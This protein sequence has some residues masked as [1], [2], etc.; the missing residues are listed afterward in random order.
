RAGGYHGTAAC[1][2]LFGDPGGGASVVA[3]SCFC[4]RTHHRSGL[5]RLPRAPRRANGPGRSAA[6]RVSPASIGTPPLL[7]VSLPGRYRSAVGG[8]GASQ[9]LTEPSSPAEA[10]ACPSGRKATAITRSPCPWSA[11]ISRPLTGSQIRTVPSPPA[12]ARRVPSWLN[13]TP[14]T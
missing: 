7:R 2:T 11:R 13:A 3:D 10:R 4:D 14:C 5:R 9:P 12:D 6:D 1:L 8:A